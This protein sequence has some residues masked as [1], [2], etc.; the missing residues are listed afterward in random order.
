MKRIT[1][2]MTSK[3][4]CSGTLTECQALK[5][6]SQICQDFLTYPNLQ[7][8]V[9]LQSCRKPRVAFG[10]PPVKLH[11]SPFLP[12]SQEI[13]LFTA[14]LWSLST[15]SYHTFF[16]FVRAPSC[17]TG[18]WCWSWLQAPETPGDALYCWSCFHLLIINNHRNTLTRSMEVQQELMRRKRSVCVLLKRPR[19]LWNLDLRMNFCLC[20]HASATFTKLPVFVAAV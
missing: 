13:L 3:N 10:N 5:H 15:C 16:F 1:C 7:S 6:G 8:I 11:S 20:L 17:R 2:S 19:C 14:L 4:V 12:D 18:R 9:V